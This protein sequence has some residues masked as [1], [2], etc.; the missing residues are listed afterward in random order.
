MEFDAPD[1]NLFEAIP[2]EDNEFDDLFGYG[3]GDDVGE[4][5]S[6]FSDGAVTSPGS[7]Q[8]VLRSLAR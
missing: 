5:F 1:D 8:F 6:G 3:A 7:S 4:D 2:F